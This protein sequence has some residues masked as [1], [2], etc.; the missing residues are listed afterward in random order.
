M[1]TIAGASQYLNAATYSNLTGKAAQGSNL[2]GNLGTVDLLDV[3]RSSSNNGI[4][5]SARARA[6]NKQFL[7]STSSNYNSLFSSTNSAYLSVEDLQKQVLALRA[8]LPSSAISDS[9]G[10]FGAEEETTGTNV[11]IEV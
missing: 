4:G 9:A 11:D 5:L 8:S 3:A 6:L 7:S 1:P 2:I 10:S